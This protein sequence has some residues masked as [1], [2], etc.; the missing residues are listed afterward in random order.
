MRKSAKKSTDFAFYKLYLL[1]SKEFSKLDDNDVLKLSDIEN[2]DSLA[3][4]VGRTD[5]GED[6]FTNL[7]RPCKPA[8]RRRKRHGKIGVYQKYSDYAFAQK[9]AQRNKSCPCR[10]EK[11]RI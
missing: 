4:Y 5:A 2:N 7:K 3:F 11:R 1:L 9:Q 8:Y 6:V 10:S